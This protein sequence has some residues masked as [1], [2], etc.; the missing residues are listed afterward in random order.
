VFLTNSSWGVLPVT[1]VE[2]RMIADG[3]VGPVTRQLMDAWR[4]AIR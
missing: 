4:V 2:Q 3:V 1:R